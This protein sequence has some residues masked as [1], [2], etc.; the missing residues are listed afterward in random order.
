MNETP[1]PR[2]TRKISKPILFLIKVYI[3]LIL[4]PTAWFLKKFG[5]EKR[6]LTM[7]GKS[8]MGRGGA[9]KVFEGYNPTSYDIF[10]STFAKSGTNWMMQIAHQIAFYGDGNFDHI[11]DVIAWPDL[12]GFMKNRIS[13][14]IEDKLVQQASP[15]K[16][17][18]I[19]THLSARNVPYNEDSYY[20]T[21]LRDPKEIFVS[22]FYFGGDSYGPLMTDVDTW[23]ELFL[24]KEQC[25]GAYISRNEG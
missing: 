1:L 13:I 2:M 5:M 9:E 14:P 20:L 24:S 25:L 6:I 22:S 8:Q 23:L 19:K 21:V 4:T 12:G 11:H 17:R 16:L 15:S 7:I 18:V 10:V 3:S